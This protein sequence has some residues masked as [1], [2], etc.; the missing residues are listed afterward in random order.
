MNRYDM[1]IVRE[2][3]P[4]I[5]LDKVCDLV[6]TSAGL[7]NVTDMRLATQSD[8]YDPIMGIKIAAEYREYLD[9]QESL[10]SEY[11]AKIEEYKAKIT[12]FS[13]DRDGMV[14]QYTKQFGG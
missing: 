7:F 10:T 8:Y 3:F 5:F 9:L 11:D 14:N 6:N 4:A 13:N 12:H 1:V 2:D